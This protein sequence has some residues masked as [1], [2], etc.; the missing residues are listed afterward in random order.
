MQVI[1]GKKIAEEIL[2]EVSLEVGKLSFKPIFCDILV[3]S[4]PSSVQYVKMKAKTAEKV[5]MEFLSANFPSEITTEQ[6]VEEIKKLNQI[7]NLC[8]L[9]VQLPLPEHVVRQQ[10]LDAIDPRIDVDCTG[11]I[12]TDLFYK[13][14]G[15]LRYPT[16]LAVLEILDSL[17]MEFE[18]K[19]FLMVGYGMLVGKPVNYLLEKRRLMIDVARSKTPDIF[20]LMKKADVVISAVGKPNMVTG[21]KIK[22]G[23]IIIDA[24]TSEFD[25]GLVGDVD[26]ESVKNIAGI[27][28]PVPGGVG[29]VTVAKLLSNVLKVAK[30]QK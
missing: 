26:F 13:G 29:P 25:G 11:K 3:G 7:K 20:D 14:R 1:D 21:D 6:L 9:I 5:G 18:R 17:A 10:V 30:L 4:D 27:I 15:F 23:A 2:S 16:A 28:S 22:L 19:K 8:G 24:G 12:N